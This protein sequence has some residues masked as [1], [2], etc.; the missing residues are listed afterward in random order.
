MEI[1][2][3]SLVMV[4]GGYRQGAN[5]P[6]SPMGPCTKLGQGL[7]TLSAQTIMNTSVQIAVALDSQQNRLALC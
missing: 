5:I 1:R 2:S 7:H 6:E 3:A 4:R